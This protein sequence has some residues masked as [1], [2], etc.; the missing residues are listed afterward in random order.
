MSKYILPFTI[1]L[2]FTVMEVRSGRF[3]H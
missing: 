2:L 3:T 1:F